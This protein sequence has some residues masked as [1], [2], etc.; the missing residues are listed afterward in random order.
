MYKLIDKM[1][2]KRL[3]ENLQTR[4]GHWDDLK[5][6]F[7]KS[8][9]TIDAIL[10]LKI[11]QELAKE[12]G[13]PIF[14]VSIDLTKAYDKADRGKVLKAIRNWAPREAHILKFLWKGFRTDLYYGKTK[15]GQISI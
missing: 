1:V 9:S 12:S 13:K 10:L 3:Q 14:L 15:V 2:D 8:K 6:G 4:Q 5:F 7:K 11:I